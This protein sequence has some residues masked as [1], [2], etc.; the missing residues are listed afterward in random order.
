MTLDLSSSLRAAAPTSPEALAGTKK[1]A[2]TTRLLSTFDI[3]ALIVGAVIGAGIF[4]SPALVAANAASTQD[5]FI[6]WALGGLIAVAGALCYAELATAH[7]HM[8][9]EYHYLRLAFGEKVGFLFAWARLTVIPTGSIA[10]LGYV[11]GDYATQLH[12]LGEFSPA[13]YAAIMIVLMTGLNVLGLRCGACTQKV[14]TLLVVAGILLIV[15]AGLTLASPSPVPMAEPATPAEATQWGL[16][17]VFVMLSY[18]GWNEAAYVSAEVNGPNRRLPRALFWS[19]AIVTAAYLLLNAAL[20][21]MLDLAGTGASTAVAADAMRALMG[22]PG[23]RLVSVLIA[24]AA[25]A[26]V[27]ATILLGARTTYAFGRDEPMFGFLGHWSIRH[28]APVRALL[29]QAAIALLLVALGGLTHS[30]F[31]T[32]VEYTAPVFWLFFV[33]TGLAL[34]VLRARRP[35]HPRPFRVPAYPFIPLVFVASSG[36][37]LYASLVHTGIGALV[38]LAVLAAGV[39]LLLVRKRA[40][41]RA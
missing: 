34:F 16:I 3:M 26:S 20:F 9:G 23:A 28:Q 7:P 10:L 21:R 40:A 5:A 15:A 31:K 35:D 33:L 30:G 39:L 36:Y 1:E 12:R 17:L 37:L 38:G 41:P 4:S 32:M 18:G 11:F 14:L 6:G 8:G 24:V 13:V 19:L 27:N 2:G 25:L 29:V 22:E